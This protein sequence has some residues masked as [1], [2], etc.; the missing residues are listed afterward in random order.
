MNTPNKLSLLRI[1]MIPIFCVCFYWNFPYHYLVSAIIFVVAACTDFLDGYIA[2][3][4]NLVTDLGKFLDAIA[5]KVLVLT[6]LVL[7]ITD[8]NIINTFKYNIGVIVGGA[9]VAIILAR[10]LMVSFFR[11]IAATKSL[12]IAADKM[13]KIKTTVQDICIVVFLLSVD[14]F[15]L[16]GG[17][18]SWMNI[19]ALVLFGISVLLTVWSGIEMFIKNKGVL[20]DKNAEKDSTSTAE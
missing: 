10:E 7:I 9:G 20:K 19:V 17:L 3:K 11:M 4:Y 12:V 15:G 1:L 18:Y 2:R 14:F 8:N 5:D 16:T 6:A 13:G